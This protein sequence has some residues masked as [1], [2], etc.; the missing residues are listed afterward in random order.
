[1]M[2]NLLVGISMS[3]KLLESC[4]S[5]YLSVVLSSRGCSKFDCNIYTRLMYDKC[6][7]S[8]RA[9]KSREAKLL[10]ELL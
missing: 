10:G 5:K 4:P 3:F 2:Q 7:K 1:M 9:R 8:G 6:P